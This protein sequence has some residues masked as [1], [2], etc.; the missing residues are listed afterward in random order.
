MGLVSRARAEVVRG[1]VRDPVHGVQIGPRYQ[2]HA[3]AAVVKAA[4][5]A[6]VSLYH[7]DRNPAP[8]A[9]VP[10]AGA[11]GTIGSPEDGSGPACGPA[12]PDQR[13]P[14]LREHEGQWPQPPLARR[15][16]PMAI[17][18]SRLASWG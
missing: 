18:V 13:R 11:G 17:W 1:R 6:L 4:Y 7:P 8:D 10:P 12:L 15:R 16:S 9:I 2:G 14:T 3:E 5:R